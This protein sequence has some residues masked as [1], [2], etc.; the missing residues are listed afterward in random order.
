MI[1]PGSHALPKPNATP[2]PSGSLADGGGALRLRVEYPANPKHLCVAAV[3]VRAEAPPAGITPLPSTLG[4]L[5]LRLTVPGCQVVPDEASLNLS[6]LNAT[7]FHLTPL[8]VGTLPAATL[9]VSRGSQPVQRIGLRL[10]SPRP[11]A[12]RT[13]LFV[14][15]LVPFVW[16]WLVGVDSTAFGESVAAK[17]PP[18][19]WTASITSAVRNTVATLT[20]VERSLRLGFLLAALLMSTAGFFALASRER[21]RTLIGPPLALTAGPPPS[22][23]GRGVPAYLTPVPPEELNQVSL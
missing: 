6:Q 1:P 22:T 4:S 16:W 13:L 5:T 11:G 15:V 17:L 12:V 21:R 8:A 7:T 2:L 19:P 3:V 23:R 18:G 10:N 14:A 9:D 20:N